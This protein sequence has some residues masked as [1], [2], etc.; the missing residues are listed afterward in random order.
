MNIIKFI[1]FGPKTT[2]VMLEN[3][4]VGKIK[5]VD[6]GHCYFPK[7]KKTGGDIFKTLSE[8]KKSLLDEAL[9]CCR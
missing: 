2:D 4:L 6:G 3:K 5:S 8:C 9:K 1:P 7:G